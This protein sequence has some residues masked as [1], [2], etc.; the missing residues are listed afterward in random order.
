MPDR[1]GPDYGTT[2]R[3][4]QRPAGVTPPRPAAG[5][6][7]RETQLGGPRSGAHR[8]AKHFRP[9]AGM[10]WQGAEA[11]RGSC[12]WIRDPVGSGSEPLAVRCRSI[13]RADRKDGV[14]ARCCR[15]T[16]PSPA[17]LLARVR[18][19]ARDVPCRCPAA[20]RRAGCEAR[21]GYRRAGG[22][23]TDVPPPVDLRAAGAVPHLRS[24]P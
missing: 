24:C 11:T 12:C 19:A 7:C 9:A 20:R 5:P 15:H 18:S 16:P 13:M 3:L 1:R 2:F 4:G 10:R 23:P 21:A 22:E 17:P 14:T 8:A 6:A